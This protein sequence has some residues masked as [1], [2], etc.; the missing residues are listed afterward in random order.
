MTNAK[1]LATKIE[2]EILEKLLEFERLTGLSVKQ[3]QLDHGGVFLDREGF[4]SGNLKIKKVT[5]GAVLR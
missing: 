5:L 4:Y 2:A 3:V 1:E